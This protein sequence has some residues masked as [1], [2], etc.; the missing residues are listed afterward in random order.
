MYSRSPSR[1]P[2]SYARVAGSILLCF[3]IPTLPGC[4]R[5]EPEPEAVSPTAKPPTFAAPKNLLFVI[6]DAF[7]ADHAGYVGY[8]RDTTPR[9]DEFARS[10]FGFTRAYSQSA[11]TL[12]SALSYFVGRY[13]PRRPKP[14][15]DGKRSQPAVARSDF[16]LAEAFSEAGY[17]TA[18]FTES[19]WISR[20][21][22][23]GQGVDVLE[24]TRPIDRKGKS[25][26]R[27]IPGATEKVF[28]RARA[29]IRGGGD[30]PWFCYL[31]AV[32]P[33]N[34]SARGTRR[35]Q[36]GTPGSDERA[37]SWNAAGAG[38]KRSSC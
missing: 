1:R 5:S 25:Y 23:F 17:R 31:H 36:T 6:L 2:R 19:P 8:A 9:L 15:S 4:G 32:R 7:N 37:R 20:G 3:L 27:R 11:N 22:G 12:T 14:K 28:R 30:Q 13:P 29:W 18:V 35:P 26:P 24:F 33:H 10:G 38:A 21:L 34:L 16:T